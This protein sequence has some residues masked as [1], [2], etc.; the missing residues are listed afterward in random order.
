[1]RVINDAI[2]R[3][4]R[5]MVQMHLDQLNKILPNPDI[6]QL[7]VIVG[8]AGYS[9]KDAAEDRVEAKLGELVGHQLPSPTGGSLPSI[10]PSVKAAVAFFGLDLPAAPTGSLD[11]DDSGIDRP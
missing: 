11:V 2:R 6:T 9:L 3:S 8:G 10:A 1:M 7:D 5:A 4:D